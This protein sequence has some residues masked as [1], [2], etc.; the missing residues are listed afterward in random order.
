VLFVFCDAAIADV[1]SEIE[2]LGE[3][4]LKEIKNH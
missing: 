3:L 2:I 1:K 4:N